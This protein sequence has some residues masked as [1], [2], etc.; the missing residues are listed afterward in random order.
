MINPR[1]ENG[2]I[3]ESD[4]K[5]GSKTTL[6]GSG[7]TAFVLETGEVPLSKAAVHCCS[8]QPAVSERFIGTAA[9]T[10]LTLSHSSNTGINFFLSE[11]ETST[12]KKK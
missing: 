2:A 12:Y 6:K 1:G 10:V 8:L 3:T 4:I 5:D 11:S 9:S 7:V